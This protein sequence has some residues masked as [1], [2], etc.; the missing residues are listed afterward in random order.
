MKI[1]VSACLLGENCKYSGGN[2]FDPII[3]DLVKGHEVIPVC[4]EVLGG[5]SVPRTPCEIK[6]GKVIDRNGLDRT[7]EFRLGA[8]KAFQIAKN[9][10]IVLAIVKKRSPS[11]AATSIYDGTFTKRLIPGEGI[12]VKELK[13]LGILILEA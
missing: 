7:K 2:N 4:P 10:K 6:Q 12:F 8:L 1:L 3:E 9:E 13:K 5:L 11:C